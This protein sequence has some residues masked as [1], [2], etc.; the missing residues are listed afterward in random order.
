MDHPHNKARSVFIEKDGNIQPS[1]APRFSRTPGQI[2][3]QA[4][5]PGENNDE[6]LQKWGFTELEIENLRNNSILHDPS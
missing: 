1:P 5:K 4:V 2:Q 3:H 6:I